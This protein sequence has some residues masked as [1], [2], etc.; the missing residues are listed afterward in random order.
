MAL[1]QRT[2]KL[3]EEMQEANEVYVVSLKEN[4]EKLKSLQTMFDDITGEKLGMEES[5][6]YFCKI[7]LLMSKSEI[8]LNIIISFK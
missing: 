8:K 5:F 3:E 7:N 2:A 6:S 1:Q 4:T